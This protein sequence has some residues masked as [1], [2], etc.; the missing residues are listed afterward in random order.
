[1]DMDLVHDYHMKLHGPRRGMDGFRPHVDLHGHYDPLFGPGFDHAP[2]GQPASPTSVQHF[3]HPPTMSPAWRMSAEASRLGGSHLLSPL[4]PS[5]RFGL[6]QA[7]PRPKIARFAPDF[8]SRGAT[9]D[10]QPPLHPQSCGHELCRRIWHSNPRK[11][12]GAK[13]GAL[14]MSSVRGTSAVVLTRGALESEIGY[15]LTA[16]VRKLEECDRG[17][18]VAAARR[19]LKLDVGISERVSEHKIVFRTLLRLC[20]NSASGTPVLIGYV[21]ERD[22]RELET[23]LPQSKSLAT[24]LFRISYDSMIWRTV[25]ERTERKVS[26]SVRTLI[27]QINISA[28]GWP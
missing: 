8:I 6:P 7:P 26:S 27:A 18:Y 10:D 1:M 4:P 25:G 12:L 13:A 2:F 19:M 22:M 3:P 15:G 24:R 23:R 5:P 16:G 21:S 14:L 17:C 11:G 20:E 9:R 28:L